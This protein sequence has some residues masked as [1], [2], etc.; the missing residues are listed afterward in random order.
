MEKPSC[1][2]CNQPL[3][4]FELPDNTRFPCLDLAAAAMQTGGTAPAIL[5]AANE[6]AVAAFLDQQIPFTMIH[7]I[8]EDTLERCMVHSA[9]TLQVILDDDAQARATASELINQSKV[10]MAR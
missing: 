6:V 9:D 8:I 4:P 10:V 7:N 2:H 1:P 3:Q 5:N